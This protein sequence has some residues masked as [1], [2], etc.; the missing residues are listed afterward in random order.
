MT[1]QKLCGDNFILNVNYTIESSLKVIQ[2]YYYENSLKL[3]LGKIPLFA[4]HL[5][6]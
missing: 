5:C 3:N 4:F 1:Q 6:K 2:H